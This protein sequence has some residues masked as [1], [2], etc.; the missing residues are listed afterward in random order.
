MLEGKT[1]VIKHLNYEKKNT[2][3]IKTKLK[4]NYPF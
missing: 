3:F 2:I 1:L 4:Y